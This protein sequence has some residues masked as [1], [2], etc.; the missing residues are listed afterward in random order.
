MRPLSR[1]RPNPIGVVRCCAPFL[2]PP[3][4]GKKNVTYES[5]RASSLYIVETG[6]RRVAPDKP[7]GIGS[8]R[9][10]WRFAVCVVAGI[11]LLLNWEAI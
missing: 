4:L 9:I 6:N 1:D 3:R 8:Y 5:E 10:A 7:S 2:P 11:S